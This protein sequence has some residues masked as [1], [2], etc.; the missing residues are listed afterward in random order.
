MTKTPYDESN[1]ENGCPDAG[2]QLAPLFTWRGR[3]VYPLFGAEGEEDE[4]AGSN[5]DSDDTDEEGAGEGGSD[6]DSTPVSREEFDKLRKQL[7]ASDKNKSAAEKRI[8]ELED[9]KKDELTKATERAEVLEKE[10]GK[11]QQ[12]NADLRLQNA[13]L[14]ADTGITWHDPADALALAERQGYLAE[15]VGDDGK[16]ESGKLKTKLKELAKAKPHLVKTSGGENGKEEAPKPPTGQ[17]V[18]SKGTSG[19]KGEDKIPSRYS[20][21][22]NR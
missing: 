18:G 3:N 1:E 14:T 21:Y 13:F 16:V 20:K 5:S 11:L 15:V 12:D 17:K 7:S 4:G 8:K 2:I 6:A 9:A 19:S 22:L 10:N